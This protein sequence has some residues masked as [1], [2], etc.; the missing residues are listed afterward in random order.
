MHSP[1]GSLR[2]V[3]VIINHEVFFFFLNFQMVSSVQVFGFSAD[4]PFRGNSDGWGI[5]LEC[6]RGRLCDRNAAYCNCVCVRLHQE[7]TERIQIKSVDMKCCLAQ[8]L[9]ES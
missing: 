4:L 3:T 5:V 1:F 9:I 8:I 7:N 6:M 2:H